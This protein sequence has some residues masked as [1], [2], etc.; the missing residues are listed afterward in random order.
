MSII[1]HTPQSFLAALE[2]EAKQL[3]DDKRKNQLLLEASKGK[4][5]TCIQYVSSN[6][7]NTEKEVQV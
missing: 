4:S 5:H 7:P 6:Y 2:V 3:E 1:K